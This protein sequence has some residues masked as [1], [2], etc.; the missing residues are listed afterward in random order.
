MEPRHHP[1]PG[2]L[3]TT[4]T[5]RCVFNDVDAVFILNATGRT[6]SHEALALCGMSS[7]VKRIVYPSGYDVNKAAYL[8]HF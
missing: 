6:E 8:P 5:V 7:G 2:D 4:S 1:R 3:Q